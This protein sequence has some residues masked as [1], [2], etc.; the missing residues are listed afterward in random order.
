MKR[1]LEAY[2]RRAEQA[3]LRG[4]KPPCQRTEVAYDD[5]DKRRSVVATESI[6]TG[7]LLG[8][9]PGTILTQAEFFEKQE[10]V[11]RSMDY[12][13]ELISG[14]VL[15]PTDMF[16]YLVDRPSNRLA[17]VNEP[18][19]DQSVNLLPLESRTAIWFFCV[20]NIERGEELLT[21]YGNTYKRNYKSSPEVEDGASDVLSA[22]QR[23]LVTEAKEKFRWFRT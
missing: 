10:F 2:S 19:K 11:K 8:V 7:E 12:S 5:S 6:R 4:L 13:F 16:G 17:L 23:Q 1:F 15:D 18:A 9:Y 21:F 3:Y 22:S 20:R 14:E